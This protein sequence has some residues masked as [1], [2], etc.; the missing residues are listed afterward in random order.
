MRSRAFTLLE[1]I[2]VVGL[3]AALTTVL[4]LILTITMGYYRR[5]RQNLAAEQA[6]RTCMA[7]ITSEF[8]QASHSPLVTGSVTI[9]AIDNTATSELAFTEPAQ[10]AFMPGMASIDT[11]SLS[12]YQ[13]VHY[14]SSG[15]ALLRDKSTLDANGGV[16]V[17]STGTV[18]DLTSAG[19][20]I[21]LTVTRI[22][23]NAI[24]I[25]VTATVGTVSYT[26]SCQ[27]VTALAP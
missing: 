6:A 10:P 1:T 12:S 26:L 4:A 19:G 18:A 25:G 17:T 7:V 24:T 11:N 8:R 13:K 9:P 23:A 5:N 2:L 3:V 16:V 15:G 14:Y 21:K 20:S 22:Y 27:E